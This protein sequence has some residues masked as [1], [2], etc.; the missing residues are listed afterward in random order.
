MAKFCFYYFFISESDKRG[1]TIFD[2]FDEEGFA[3]TGR[4]ESINNILNTQEIVDL[5]ANSA[6]EKFKNEKFDDLTVYRFYNSSLGVH[7][8][9]SNKNE[10]NYIYNSLDNYACE[11]DAFVGQ[12]AILS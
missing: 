9:T 12:S 2:F 7:F 4:I 5:I 11:I 6:E 10:R 3:G 8:Y 1:V